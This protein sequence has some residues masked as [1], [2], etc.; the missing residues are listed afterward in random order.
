MYYPQFCL[1]WL[2]P[3]T[4]S[5]DWR[6]WRR[7]Q[8]PFWPC[9]VRSQGWTGS[10]C[11]SGGYTPVSKIFVIWQS[12][13]LRKS[14][15]CLLN[16]KKKRMHQNFDTSSL[17]FCPCLKMNHSARVIRAEKWIVQFVLFVLKNEI[18]Q[19][20][21]FVLENESFNSCYSCLKL[22]RSIR[23]VRA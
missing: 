12:P 2:S 17:F 23:V 19:F 20:V 1:F 22:N 10:P 15:L 6:Q 13:G 7:R 21:L 14:R 16:I 9:Q 18:V 5:S 3:S 11:L 8:S 4:F